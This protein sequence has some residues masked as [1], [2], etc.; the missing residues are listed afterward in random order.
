MS[1]TQ[2][3]IVV[4]HYNTPDSLLRLLRSIPDR[5]EVEVIV[6]D[7]NSTVDLTDLEWE[8][9]SWERVHFYKND[10]GVKGAG[11]SRNVA[12]RHAKG[13][14]LLFADADDFFV[15]DV[16]AV[17]EPYLNSDYDMVYFPPTSQDIVTGEVSSRHVMY[18][19]LVN[20]YGS[21]PTDK[22]LTEMKYGFCTPWS[23]LIRREILTK[24]DIRFDEIMVSN[25]IMC[26]TK[27]AFYSDKVAASKD[28]IYCVTRGGKTL[29]AKKDE[30]R[31]DTRIDVL[32]ARYTFLREHLSKK[33]F[34]Y[35]HIDRLALGKLVDVFIEHWGIGKLFAILKKYHQH[36]VHYF[37][38]GLLNPVTLF[39][40]AKIEL[41]WWMDIKKHR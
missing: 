3:S 30:Q 22:T 38:I 13:D 37:D 24:H 15:G 21:K 16:W 9:Q 18:M 28:T 10:S 40:K 25:D 11:A 29:T 31:F 32:I 8:L 41:S 2:L 19:E 6:T 23:K 7:D 14:W 20:A 5:D 4:P 1:S 35:A 39:H 36:G 27:T 12:L 17:L 26:M 33:E 34:R